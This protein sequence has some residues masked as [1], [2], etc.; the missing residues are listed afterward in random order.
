MIP[1]RNN[2]PE[3]LNI[4]MNDIFFLNS[5]LSK[6]IVLNTNKN[7]ISIIIFLK[8]CIIFIIP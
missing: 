3:V 7:M 2:V 5:I 1:R 4:Q 6:N 8:Y